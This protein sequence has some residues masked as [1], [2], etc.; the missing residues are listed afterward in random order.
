MEVTVCRILFKSNMLVSNSFS[1]LTL[2]CGFRIE[3][4]WQN[5]ATIDRKYVVTAHIRI[6]I[7]TQK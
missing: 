3:V 4:I 2:S 6:T 7:A 5:L 1:I